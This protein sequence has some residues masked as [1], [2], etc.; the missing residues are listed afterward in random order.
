MG[1]R[2]VFDPCEDSTTCEMGQ[3]DIQINFGVSNSVTQVIHVE[4]K[5]PLKLADGLYEDQRPLNGF[6]E[7]L[8]RY[9]FCVN[10]V[11]LKNSSKSYGHSFLKNGLLEL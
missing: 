2:Y 10:K 3:F 4:N 6:F 1:G 9:V 7:W 5:S 8:H 11:N